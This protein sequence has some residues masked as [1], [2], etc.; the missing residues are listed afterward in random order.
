MDERVVLAHAVRRIRSHVR[1]LPGQPRSC[2]HDGSRVASFAGMSERVSRSVPLMSF[3]LLMYS[4]AGCYLDHGRAG[5]ERDAGTGSVDAAPTPPDARPT[6]RDAGSACE[7]PLVPTRP[8]RACAAESIPHLPAER[9]GTLLVSLDGCFCAETL[10]CEARAAGDDAI[11]LSVG[12]CP[13]LA[14][15][16]ECVPHLDVACEIPALP[17]GQRDVRVNGEHAFAMQVREGMSAWGEQLCFSL[18]PEVSEGLFCEAPGT[19]IVPPFGECHASSIG[20]DESLEVRII[21]ACPP[22]FAVPGACEIRTSDTNQIDVR[23][24]RRECECPTCGA[25]APGC[26]PQERTCRLPPL[27]EGLWLVHVEGA[28]GST[29]VRV[30]P[31]RGPEVCTDVP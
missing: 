6:S 1:N 17:P 16:S 5:M 8:T 24:L 25:C 30:G 28:T 23:P 2:S 15:C 22:C 9:P 31:S 11:E 29:A 14:D 4:L 26:F 10:H 27:P 3:A 7:V 20:T 21:D 19:A 18:A 12:L 13:S